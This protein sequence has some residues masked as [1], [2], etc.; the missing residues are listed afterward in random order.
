MLIFEEQYIFLNIKY[1]FLLI[2]SSYNMGVLLEEIINLKEENEKLNER[3]KKVENNKIKELENKI[4]RLEGYHKKD[5]I[6]NLLKI[7]II[8]NMN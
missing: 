1:V 7:K 6:Q 3:I 5:T 4:K 2:S 8:E